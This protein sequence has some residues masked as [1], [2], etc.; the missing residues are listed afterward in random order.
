[1]SILWKRWLS[2][3]AAAV[4]LFGLVLAGAAF[5]ATSAP[6]EALMRTLNPAAQE[7]FTPALRFAVA[8]MGCVT[9]GWGVTTYAAM[10]AAWRMGAD[11]RPLWLGLTAAIALW[12][13]TDSTLSIATGYGLNALSNAAFFAAFLLPIWRSGVLSGGGSQPAAVRA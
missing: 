4:T 12:F 13:V 6:V 3:W 5:D 2:L 8:L 1:M 11:A 9:L 10:Q 7:D